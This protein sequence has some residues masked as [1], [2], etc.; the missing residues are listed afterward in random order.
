MENDNQGINW[1]LKRCMCYVGA[2]YSFCHKCYKLDV[3][4]VLMSWYSCVLLMRCYTC[5]NEMFYVC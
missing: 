5:V 3:T 1:L 2:V 4:H